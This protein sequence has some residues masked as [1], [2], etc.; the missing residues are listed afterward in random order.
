MLEHDR[1][2]LALINIGQAITIDLDEFLLRIR[3]VV[4]CHMSSI[5]MAG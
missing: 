5:S 2:A 1:I 4:E 3:F